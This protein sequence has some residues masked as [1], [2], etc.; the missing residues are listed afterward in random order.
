M[1]SQ[2]PRRGGQQQVVQDQST[3][4]TLQSSHI[5][6]LKDSTS[7][8]K[9]G[10]LNSSTSRAYQLQQ[11]TSQNQSNLQLN[12]HTSANLAAGLSIAN[13]SLPF[14]AGSILGSGPVRGQAINMN[15]NF[16]TTNINMN[17]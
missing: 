7:L 6:N 14:G 17:K 9:S 5:P 8:R 1:T 15:F 11:K 16:N 12:N 13:A 2:G 10:M 3:T 4:V